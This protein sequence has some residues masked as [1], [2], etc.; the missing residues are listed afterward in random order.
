M[1]LTVAIIVGLWLG[2]MLTIALALGTD[3]LGNAESEHS[4]KVAARL[5]HRAKDEGTDSAG[6]HWHAA[7]S[8]G[9]FVWWAGTEKVLTHESRATKA[10]RWQVQNELAAD[11]MLRDN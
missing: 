4:A 3:A 1:N 5:Q 8:F 11:R 10:E 7:Q 2:V 6:R 9:R